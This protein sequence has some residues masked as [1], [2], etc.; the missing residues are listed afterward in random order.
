LKNRREAQAR[1]RASPGYAKKRAKYLEKSKDR[2]KKVQAAYMKKRRKEDPAFKLSMDIRAR[3]CSAFK[4]IA[5]GKPAKTEDLVGCTWEEAREH[6]EKQF[7]EN[8]TWENHGRGGWEIEHIVPIHTFDLEDAA[9][10]FKAFHYT[11]LQPMWEEDHKKKTAEERSVSA[12][13]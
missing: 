1:Y 7:D 6:M 9:Q 12:V 13:H 2:R 4:A 8:M 11:N 5:V 10:C 3:T